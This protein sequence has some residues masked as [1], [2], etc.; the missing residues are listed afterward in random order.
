MRSVPVLCLGHGFRFRA[1][2]SLLSDELAGTV[3]PSGLPATW[4]KE[5]N[6]TRFG[7]EL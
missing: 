5:S 7:P 6:T 1:Y 4:A 2:R 3:F